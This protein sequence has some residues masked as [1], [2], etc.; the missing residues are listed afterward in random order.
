MTVRRLDA[1]NQRKRFREVYGRRGP[2]LLPVGPSYKRKVMASRLDSAPKNRRRTEAKRIQD[3]IKALNLS[4]KTR[5]DKSELT[6]LQNDAIDDLVEVLKAIASLLETDAAELPGD[7]LEK[8]LVAMR[9]V[10]QAFGAELTL[11]GDSQTKARGNR[12]QKACPPGIYQA[13]SDWVLIRRRLGSKDVLRSVRHGLE[14][15]VRRGYTEEEFDV[16]K[17]IG[18]A[19]RGQI[20]QR[21]S[22]MAA[23]R[24]RIPPDAVVFINGRFSGGGVSPR[25]G[26]TLEWVRSRVKT[27]HWGKVQRYVRD[28]YP[29]GAAPLGRLLTGSVENFTKW[30][31]RNGDGLLADLPNKGGI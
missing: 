20:I 29:A 15:G 13:V 6:G 26:I 12:I 22:A 3:W 9:A 24:F 14:T 11:N 23:R 8:H 19:T 16:L 5:A 18:A 21:G 31:T 27:I 30:I 1:R 10:A 7:V 17:R 4:S 28:T 2:L 25:N